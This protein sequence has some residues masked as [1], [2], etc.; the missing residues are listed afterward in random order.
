MRMRERKTGER[1]AGV[2]RRVE[3]GSPWFTA[4]KFAGT[5]PK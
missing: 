3:S 1:E 4:S 5:A 2:G